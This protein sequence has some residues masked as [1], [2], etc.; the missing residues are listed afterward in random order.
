MPR[1]L[2]I[3]VTGQDGAYLSRLL[4][5][6]GYAVSGTSRSPETADYYRLT[7]LGTL[8]DVD[9]LKLDPT[10]AEQVRAVIDRIDPAEIYNFSGQSSVAQSFR[11]PV[12]TLS[13]IVVATQNLLEA[14]RQRRCGAA[15]YNAGSSE[16]FGDI[17]DR[18]ADETTPFSPKSPYG[19]AKSCAFWQ[20]ATYRASYQLRAATG[21]LFNH[22]SYLR[23][24][25]FVTM[26]IMT[27]AWAIAH[28]EPMQLALGDVDIARDWGWAPEYVEAMWR[29][30]QQREVQ[31][32][33]V[34]TGETISLRD[35]ASHVFSY[36]GLD[37][38][39]H[40]DS[41]PT[42]KRPNELHTSR[43]NPARA[44]ADLGWSAAHRGRGLV[45]RLCADYAAE[46]ERLW[47]KNP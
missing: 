21:I 35:F 12:E 1:A 41:D 16:C 6:K 29:M 37:L 31:D 17:G 36:F 4:I 26:K 8:S 40:L 39:N 44:F 14:I 34:A 9:M 38:T 25:Q 33:V 28:G 10:N 42:L 27:S 45:N 32:Y 13:S 3:G 11:E 2:I 22:E 47:R 7:A 18:A 15:F 43:A 23:G 19:V 5:D 20:V 24:T 30:L 46:K